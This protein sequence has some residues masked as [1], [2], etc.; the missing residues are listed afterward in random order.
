MSIAMRRF[1]FAV[2]ASCILAISYTNSSQAFPALTHGAATTSE[3]SNLLTDV[4]Y[5][6]GGH[7]GRSYGRA[8]GYGGRSYVRAGGRYYGHGG[9]YYGHGYGYGYGYGAAAAAGVVLGAAA[10]SSGYYYGAGP[11]YF[12]GGGCWIQTDSRGY[13]YYGP[14][15]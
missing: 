1:G 6:G 4:R 13:G 5:Y 3:I 14:C 2:A 12:G 10:V 8:A 9:R 15:Y 7:G 11:G